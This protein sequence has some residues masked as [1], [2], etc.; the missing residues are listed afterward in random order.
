M[1][2]EILRLV[3]DIRE[4]EAYPETMREVP[5]RCDCNRDGLDNR[6]GN[7]LSA[8]DGDYEDARTIAIPGTG[9]SRE[10]RNND[11]DG[12]VVAEVPD[13]ADSVFQGTL[14]ACTDV[15][16]GRVGS[17]DR[18]SRQHERLRR[19]AP[20]KAFEHRGYAQSHKHS[21]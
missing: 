5:D 3:G 1:P 11:R 21:V 10:G 7:G 12:K 9:P 17:S 16:G 2:L 13:H 4:G 14:R 6:Y 15:D 8:D 18:H 19:C 20:E